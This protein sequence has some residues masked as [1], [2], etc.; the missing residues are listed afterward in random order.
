MNDTTSRIPLFE[1]RIG[2]PLDTDSNRLLEA[3]GVL[4]HEESDWESRLDSDQETLKDA[5]RLLRHSVGPSGLGELMG[6]Q[7]KK[8]RQMLEAKYGFT[9]VE[10]QLEVG[11][12]DLFCAD[13]IDRVVSAAFNKA[14]AEEVQILS[15]CRSCRGG[16]SGEN[17]SFCDHASGRL[18][19]LSGGNLPPAIGLRIASLQDAEDET[20]KFSSPRGNQLNRIGYFQEEVYPGSESMYDSAEVSRIVQ[21]HIASKPN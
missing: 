17:T 13:Y 21:G 18:Y 7:D 6:T 8:T 19:E 10:A 12:P 3:M 1:W 5:E 20:G 15:N 4:D 14:S 11:N 9:Q 16:R 2:D